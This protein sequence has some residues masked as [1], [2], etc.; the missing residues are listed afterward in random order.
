MSVDDAISSLA[1]MKARHMTVCWTCYICR[2]SVVVIESEYNES[3]W[4]II[5]S[6]I[7]ESL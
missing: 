3:V 5:W 7:S 1:S 4:K 6:D 2:S